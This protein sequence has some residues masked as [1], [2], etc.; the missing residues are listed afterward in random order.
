MTSRSLPVP[1]LFSFSIC[2][3]STDAANSALE[4]S[5]NPTV[6][7]NTLPT[8]KRTFGTASEASDAA[9]VRI[10]LTADSFVAASEL[11]L[12][13]LGLGGMSPLAPLSTTSTRDGHNPFVIIIS[14]IFKLSILCFASS[15]RLHVFRCGTTIFAIH[16]PPSSSPCIAK[17]LPPKQRHSAAVFRTASTLSPI[18]DG[19][20]VLDRALLLEA[21]VTALRDAVVT[22][23]SG[24]CSKFWRMGMKVSSTCFL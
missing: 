20:L 13:E 21:L 6:T 18:S 9:I 15:L 17:L 19:V 24:S 11:S 14:I 16:S 4:R 3:S 1:L 7:P 22:S 8:F 10:A 23:G 5:N 12:C 2:C